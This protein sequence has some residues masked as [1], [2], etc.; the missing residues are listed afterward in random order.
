MISYKAKKFGVDVG[1]IAPAYTSKK[2]SKCGTIGIRNDKSFM[3]PACG[4]VD[5][6]DANAAFNIAV[7]PLIDPLHTDRDVCKGSTDAPQ[8]GVVLSSGVAA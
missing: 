2:C 6:A 4:H 1:L 3:C 5:H 8:R 7:W